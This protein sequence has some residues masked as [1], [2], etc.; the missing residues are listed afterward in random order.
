[1][2]A[3]QEPA[4]N[5]PE[6]K[7]LRQSPGNRNA[8]VFIHGFTGHYIS[9]WRDFPRFV[10]D[11]PSFNGWDVF[12]YGYQTKLLPFFG[13][14]QGNPPLPRLAV[15]L[16]TAASMEPLGDYSGLALVAHSMGGLVVQQALVI[17][18]E[19]R[20]RVTH[21]FCYG[22]PS[23]GLA[24]ARLGSLFN[25]Q[26]KD[27]RAKGPF[28]RKLR[29]R[30]KSKVE[31]LRG[32]K[33]FAIA[34]DIDEF[35]PA[36]SSLS[37]FTYDQCRVVRGNHLEIVKPA[38]PEADSY[39]VFRD[40]ILD[41]L[42][43]LPFLDAAHVASERNDF[44]KVVAMLEPHAAELDDV[45]MAKLVIALSELGESNKVHTL[46]EAHPWTGETDFLGVWA[47]QLKRRWRLYGHRAD[48]NRSIDL[49][50]Q[51][52]EEA[53]KNE[54]HGQILYHAINLAHLLEIGKHQRSA[55]RDY[56]RK[57]LVACAAAS[58][59]DYWVIVT[60]A[61]AH[62]YLNQLDRAKDL[63]AEALKLNPAPR[64]LK[65]TY[66]QACYAL[67]SASDRERVLKVFGDP[68]EFAA[69]A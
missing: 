2:K 64:Q 21:A 69:A 14:W 11:D 16:Q 15:Q 22:T 56:A 50:R 27:M 25:R 3:K 43:D 45:N 53:E 34:G 39:R 66:Q 63:Y 68:V 67:P 37:P 24:K 18:E 54:D 36:D 17:S 52:C 23:A 26:A 55:A 47:G 31:P 10:Q 20:Q 41:E 61:E 29:E 46:L 28:I 9:T 51:G 62:I 44:R 6:L 48:I 32:L 5:E 12:C 42:K 60:E 7:A 4:K 33:F 8:I 59:R 49:Y 38:T 13:F 65:T 30:W 57:A 35:V 1:M 40:G 58:P 19:L